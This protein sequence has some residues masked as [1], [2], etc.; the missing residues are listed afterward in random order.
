MG[1]HKHKLLVRTWL[2]SGLPIARRTPSGGPWIW[3]INRGCP[4]RTSGP[5]YHSSA[6][7]AFWRQRVRQSIRARFRLGLGAPGGAQH[8]RDSLRVQ[9]RAAEAVPGAVLPLGL[10]RRTLAG[11]QRRGIWRAAFRAVLL[12][13]DAISL[14]V[15]GVS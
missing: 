12:A 13:L 7:P 2:G 1:A 15:A 9:S 4:K 10:L 14:Q 11:R 8:A 5:G 6:L 3:A